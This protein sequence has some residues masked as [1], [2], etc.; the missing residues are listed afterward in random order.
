MKKTR[1]SPSGTGGFRR[2]SGLAIKR[3]HEAFMTPFRP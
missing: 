3:R 2:Q 1:R